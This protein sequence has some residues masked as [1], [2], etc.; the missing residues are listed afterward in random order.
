MAKKRYI[1]SKYI[2]IDRDDKQTLAL[3]ERET[4]HLRGRRVVRKGEKGD[5]TFP[6]RVRGGEHGSKKYGGWILGRSPSV[7]VRGDSSKRGTLRRTL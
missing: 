3:R 5:R 1:P 4:G 6:R 7:L 2:Y